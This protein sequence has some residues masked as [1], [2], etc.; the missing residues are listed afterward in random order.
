VLSVFHGTDGKFDFH[1]QKPR[2]EEL[3]EFGHHPDH[4]EIPE[5]TLVTK[6]IAPVWMQQCG[7]EWLYRLAPRC[8]R[9]AFRKAMPPT[10]ERSACH[11]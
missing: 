11:S 5:I 6:R 3:Y 1:L 10:L 7:L 9:A 4:R 8:F 2:L